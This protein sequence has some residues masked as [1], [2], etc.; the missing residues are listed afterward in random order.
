MRICGVKTTHDGAIALI[1]DGELIGSFEAEKQGNAERYAKIND[2]GE[3]FS[4]LS[5]AGA[6]EADLYAFDGWYKT[7]KILK[8][9]GHEVE[10]KLA[11][12]RRGILHSDLM[13]EYKFGVFDLEYFSYSHYAGHV[14]AAYCTSPFAQRG[15]DSYV[16]VWD[17][18]MFPYL[19]YFD[20]RLGAP[21]W[22]APLF[23]MVSHTYTLLVN[24][25][26]PFNH[27]L[28]YPYVLGIAGK[29]MAYIA[30]GTPDETAID[31]IEAAYRQ[32][33]EEEFS[34]LPSLHDRFMQPVLGDAIA[35]RMTEL[36]KVV[37][38]SDADMLA[39]IHV[40]IE[41]KLVEGLRSAL[42]EH[43]TGVQ[44]LCMSGGTALNIK[45]NAAI[46]RAG[47]FADVWIPPFPNDSGSAIGTAC[48]AMLLHT[49]NRALKWDLFKGPK[50]SPSEP[51]D[52]WNV[53]HCSPDELGR[54]IHERGEP[55][56]VLNGRAELGPRALGGRSILAPATSKA[57]RDRL[58]LMKQREWYRP[59]A[60]ICLEH[61]SGEIFDP[62]SPDPYMLFE[63]AVRPEWRDRV[64]AI[65]HLDGTA[66][67]QTIN[68]EQNP[69]IFALLESYERAS[70]IP[71]LCNT[72]A[73]LK[74]CGFFSDVGSAMDWGQA[75]MI[76]SENTLYEAPT[77][78]EV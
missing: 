38:V 11:P 43:R 78:E 55:V 21:T 66:R 15:E 24:K 22:G 32:A 10:I 27:P 67:L 29:V 73:N 19:Y 1:E 46:R 47:L 28:E 13:H 77:R 65:C 20:H 31:A 37:G 35:A 6:E 40:C 68:A 75:S 26:A 48:C 9:W 23:H 36:L 12:Y 39:S 33:T 74:N 16:L 34:K 52:G 57:M 42:A 14:A 4:R 51:R 59:V 64:P 5:E 63:H 76:W 18:H 56:V 58:N 3:I 72:S 62:G 50:L 8:W 69:V 17:A 70:G 49:Q 71:L 41:R 60:P 30:L 54:L 45:W 53:R 61:R 7:H 2:F 25:Y 44:N